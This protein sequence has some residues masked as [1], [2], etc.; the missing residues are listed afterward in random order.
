MLSD[1]HM[2]RCLIINNTPRG[3]KR[4]TTYPYRIL[5]THARRAKANSE[6]ENIKNKMCKREAGILV[7]YMLIIMFA[8]CK[9]I[10]L[11]KL[12]VFII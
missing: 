8:L 7:S 6:Q 12:I 3:L 5:H 4:K 10:V 1:V 11:F 2:G 9:S